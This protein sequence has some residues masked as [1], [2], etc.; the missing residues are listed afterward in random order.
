DTLT[1]SRNMHAEFNS[2]FEEFALVMEL[3][4]SSTGASRP[5]IFTKRPLA[6]Y[7]PAGQLEPWQ[8]GRL[9][10]KIAAMLARHPEAQLDMLRRYVLL[11]GWIKGLNAV[12]AVQALGVTRSRADTFL[13]ETTLRAIHDL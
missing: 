11:Y 4:A 5:H 10:S 1:R 6:I 8:T 2:P 13:A 7:V 12:Q 9:E 3:R